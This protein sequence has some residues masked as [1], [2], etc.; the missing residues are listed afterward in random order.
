MY[1]R[2]LIL[3][4]IN[5]IDEC[6]RR[7]DRRFQSI[8]SPED[9]LN[10]EKGLDLL[11]AIGM[12]LITIGENVKKID[13]ETEGKLLKSIPDIHWVGVKGVR[14]ILAHDYFGID[15]EEIYAICTNDIKPLK[16]ALHKMREV[17]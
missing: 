10:T 3:E 5:Q 13:K 7:I 9:F 14:D 2:S 17:L 6:I 12:M 8:T 11:D 16:E 15:H 1:D 4:R